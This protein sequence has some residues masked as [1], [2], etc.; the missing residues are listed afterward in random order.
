MNNPS[1]ALVVDQYWRL[2][3]LLQIIAGLQEGCLGK[4]GKHRDPKKGKIERE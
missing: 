4:K 1:N 3:W 2:K